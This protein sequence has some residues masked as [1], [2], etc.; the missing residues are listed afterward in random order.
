MGHSQDSIRLMFYNLYRFPDNPPANREFIL[1]DIVDKARPD[2]LMACEITHE[3]GANSILETS[4]QTLA[5]SFAASNFVYS[6]TAIEDPLQQMVYYNTRK[7]HL[8]KEQIHLTEVRDINQYTF[9]IVGSANFGDSLFIESFVTHLKAGEGSENREKRLAMVDT[10]LKALQKVPPNHFVLFAGDFN[11]YN[12]REPAY[13]RLLDSTH[14]IRMVDPINQP[15]NWHDHPEFS[16]I[17]TQATR[18]TLSG[19]GLGGASGGMDD[20]FD[21]ILMSENLKQHPQVTYQPGSYK[22]FGNNGNCLDLAINNDSCHG[23][24]SLALRNL[25]FQMSDHTPVVMTLKTTFD[26]SP[27]SLHESQANKQVDFYFPKG[28]MVKDE[29]V[30]SFTS[31]NF[32]KKKNKILRL[33]DRNGRLIGSYPLSGFQKQLILSTGFLSPGLYYLQWGNKTKRFIKQ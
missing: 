29:L 20:R 26:F 6:L 32:L 25:L 23:V 15:G 31:P 17:H 13:Q 5:D 33:F 3:T 10:F 22:A 19:F 14:L 24:Y 30:L 11:F 18:K 4:F 21:F 16:A 28:N 2:L 8:I 7:M 27:T 12:D 9:Y 1:Q